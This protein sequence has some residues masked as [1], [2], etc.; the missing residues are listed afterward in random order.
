MFARDIAR[1]YRQSVGGIL[2]AFAPAIVITA[3]ATMIEHSRIITLPENMDLPYAPFVLI[4][5][6]LWQ[7]FVESINAPING[8]RA[9][10]GTIARSSMPAEAIVLAR[11]GEILFGFAIKLVLIVGTMLWF[12]IPC[13]GWII[14]APITLLLMIL[15]GMGIG[16]VLAP[17]NIFYRDIGASIAPITTFWLFLTPVIVPVPRE[18]WAAIFV[19]NNP[20]TPLLSSTRELLTTGVLTMPIGLAIMTLVTAIVFLFGCIFF[21]STLP[22]ILDQSNV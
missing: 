22:L 12:Q 3:W 14:F 1:E 18:G 16:L 13:T 10:L 8:L 11:F 7:S 4:S 15:F 9:E 2:L 5:L 20:V 19:R 17:L 6:M 21:R